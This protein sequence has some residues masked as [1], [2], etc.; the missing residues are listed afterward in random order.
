MMLT[1]EERRMLRELAVDL[2]RASDL[3]D[4]WRRIAQVEAHLKTLTNG[5]TQGTPVVCDNS[6]DTPMSIRKVAA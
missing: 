2:L 1:Y 6:K 3:T 5:H 4:P